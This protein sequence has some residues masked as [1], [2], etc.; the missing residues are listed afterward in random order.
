MSLTN[1]L[2]ADQPRGVGGLTVRDRFITPV[3]RFKRAGGDGLDGRRG[4]NGSDGSDGLPGLDGVNGLPGLPGLP[5]ADGSNGLPGSD[6]LPGLPGLPGADG[7]DGLPGLPGTDGL[8]GAD[9]LPGPYGL[10]GTDGLPGPDGLPGADGLP[11]EDGLDGSDGLPGLPG[12]KDSI[13]KLENSFRRFAVLEGPQAWLMDIVPA[14]ASPREPFMEATNG[15]ILRFRSEDAKH[16][17]LLGLRKDFQSWYAP[18]AT[19]QEYLNHLANWQVLNGA[20]KV[21]TD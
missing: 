8:P 19:E 11:G 17:L 16:D 12:P 15:F 21:L 10:P 7:V 5:G 6:G 14:E 18:S 4:T 20:S 9:G 3:D 2:G 13:I 1:F